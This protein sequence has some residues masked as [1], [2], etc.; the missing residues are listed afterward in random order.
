MV[1]IDENVIE[2]FKFLLVSLFAPAINT[3]TQ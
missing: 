1:S 3:E 2:M